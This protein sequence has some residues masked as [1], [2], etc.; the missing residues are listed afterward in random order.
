MGFTHFDG[1]ESQDVCFLAGKQLASF[2]AKQGL[3]SHSGEI[4]STTGKVLGQQQG[5]WKYT[6]GQRRGLGIPDATPWY[7]VGLNADKNQVIVGKNEELFQTELF[8]T[9]VQ[10][11]IAAPEQWHGK[12][13]LRSRHQAADAQLVS[14][15]NGRWQ[16]CFTEAQRAVTPGQFAVFYENDL[17]VGSGIISSLR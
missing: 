6:V 17:V 13:Q 7:V 16:V 14:A 9:D 8:L 3:Q 2:L 11:H 12:V 4:I 1:S 15:G 5:Y 10:W